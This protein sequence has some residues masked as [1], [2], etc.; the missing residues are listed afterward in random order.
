[1]TY[2]NLTSEKTEMIERM[3]GSL[4]DNRPLYQK[5]IE[6]GILSGQSSLIVTHNISD[7]DKIISTTGI[8]SNENE[9]IVLPNENVEICVTKSNIRIE[10]KDLGNNIY[11]NSYVTVQYTKTTDIK[12]DPYQYYTVT[13]TSENI[14]TQYMDKY[15]TTYYYTDTSQSYTT[16]TYNLGNM[17]YAYSNDIMWKYEPNIHGLREYMFANTLYD[18]ISDILIDESNLSEDEQYFEDKI[19]RFTLDLLY[20]FIDKNIFTDIL[21]EK[22][23][24]YNEIN[25]IINEILDEYYDKKKNEDEINEENIWLI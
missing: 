10:S 19:Y 1:M 14:F 23:Y 9:Y 11:K 15:Y 8:A 3:V 17:N 22:Q 16:Y 25:S 21:D 6:C 2:Y 18:T 24:P 5:T 12:I 20:E 4:K 7:I 13:D